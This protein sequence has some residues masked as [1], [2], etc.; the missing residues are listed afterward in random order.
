[1]PTLN[2]FALRAT[3]VLPVH[4]LQ[5]LRVRTLARATLDEITL[6]RED[7]Y[8][9]SPEGRAKAQSM[10][11]GEQDA[12]GDRRDMLAGEICAAVTLAQDI[13]DS[14]RAADY[15]P[16]EYTMGG[17]MGRVMEDVRFYRQ[18]NRRAAFAKYIPGIETRLKYFLAN[19]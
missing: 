17:E 2:S 19:S 13:A 11:C 15:T 3:A 4:V 6:A 9:S 8:W 7:A 10:W 12:M 1:M 18:F 5:T 14:I 16:I